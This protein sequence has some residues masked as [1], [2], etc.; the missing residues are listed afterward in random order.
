MS[1]N[2]LGEATRLNTVQTGTAAAITLALLLGPSGIVSAASPAEA[3]GTSPP[4]IRPL[5]RCGTQLLDDATQQSAT[6]RTLS[7]RLAASDVLVYVS[8]AL[9]P[10][11]GRGMPRGKTRFISATPAVRI[12]HIWVDPL[13]RP[14][15]RIAVLA[16]ELQHALEVAGAPGVNDLDSFRRF[17][18]GVGTVGHA[19]GASRGVRRYETAAAVA[20]E[21]R[22]LRELGQRTGPV[23][24]GAE[25]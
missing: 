24:P 4:H 18:E 12:L 10:T 16:H 3:P 7:E 15:T 23:T 1:G 5:D 14:A 21:T 20:V 2:G 9:P 17:F 19:T 13:Q 22:V 8:T 25:R 6:V 11:G